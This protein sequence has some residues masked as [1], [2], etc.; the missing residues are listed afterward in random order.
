[1]GKNKIFIICFIFI[2][3]FALSLKWTS[4]FKMYKVSTN[5]NIRN[6]KEIKLERYGIIYYLPDDYELIE[7]N[8]EDNEV[9]YHSDFKSKDSIVR[10]IVE[11]L[12]IKNLEA[13]LENSKKVQLEQLILSFLI[14]TIKGSK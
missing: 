5:L 6:F 3:V 13:Y 14:F 4:I 12:N 10:G 7:I 1:M 9:L 8:F 2:V 11:V